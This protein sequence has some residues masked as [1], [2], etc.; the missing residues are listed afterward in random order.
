MEGKKSDR[1]Q[2]VSR[3]FDQFVQ[4]FRDGVDPTINIL[5]L[6]LRSEH[7]DKKRSSNRFPPAEHDHAEPLIAG[8]CKDVMS[9]T[10]P[11]QDD[12]VNCGKPFDSTNNSCRSC[13]TE[14]P[15]RHNNKSALS[16]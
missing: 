12:C 2:W 7:I 13:G 9:M 1:P 14:R 5:L 4:D 3:V 8:L 6:Q 10:I 15:A 11:V 16:A